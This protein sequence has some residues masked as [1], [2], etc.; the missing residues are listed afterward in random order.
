ME[1]LQGIEG[2]EPTAFSTAYTYNKMKR[3]VQ[4]FVSDSLQPG[5]RVLDIGCNRAYDL[6]RLSERFDSLGLKMCG[7][8]LSASDLQVARERAATLSPSTSMSFQLSAVEKLPYRDDSFDVVTCSE[9]VEH[10][11]D[12]DRAL[13]EMSRV[14]K[15]GGVLALTT[16]NVG[17]KL[18]KLRKFLPRSLRDKSNEWREMQR[19][20]N[21]IRKTEAAVNLPHLS[22][23]S[24][25]EWCEKCREV[26]LDVVEIKRGSLL[27]GDPYLDNR[28]GLWAISVIADRILD[29]I[30][31]DW[32][33][34]VL[35]KA[36]KHRG[37]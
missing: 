4:E 24:A 22:E 21:R 36:R 27:Y 2:V 12:P 30:T 15:P 26:G 3:I 28:P 1:R 6:L 37:D 11:P 17:N 9:V 10:L 23:L 13:R 33:W 7:I 20:L 14:T 25:R 29:H 31:D 18:H 32:S 35:I 34:Q 16:P 5:G 19:E 8:D